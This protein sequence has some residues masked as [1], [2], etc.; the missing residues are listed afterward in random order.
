MGV[1]FIFGGKLRRLVGGGGEGG[2]VGPYCVAGAGAAALASRVF[3]AAM[4]LVASYPSG[5]AAA[6]VGA[7][8]MMWRCRGGVG[9]TCTSGSGATVPRA[10]Y[11]ERL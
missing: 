5:A 2:A 4:P 10:Q 7:G 8:A 11:M 9:G 6:G 3:S 1:F